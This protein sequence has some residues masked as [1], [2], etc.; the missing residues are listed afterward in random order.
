M[1]YNGFIRIA[2]LFRASRVL[3]GRSCLLG[4]DEGLTYENGERSLRRNEVVLVPYVGEKMMATGKFPDICII[5]FPNEPAK[6]RDFLRSAIRT[7]M[8]IGQAAEKNGVRIKDLTQF[9]VDLSE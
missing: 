4:R 7:K 6:V 3:A 8:T 9:Y 2:E 1:K 5:D